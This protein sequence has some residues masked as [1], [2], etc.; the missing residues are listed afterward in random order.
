MAADFF[1][2]H[3]GYLELFNQSGA[4]AASLRV[5]RQEIAFGNERLVG[6]ANWTNV[7]RSFDGAR[8]SLGPRV[9]A[10][11]TAPA[12]WSATLAAATVEERGTHFGA[13]P[14]GATRD[15]FMM[16]LYASRALPWDA[17][18]DGTALYD[19][20]GHYR[21]YDDA[22]R[23]TLDSRFKT[24]LGPAPLRLDVEGA[25]QQ[26]RQVVVASGQ[27]QSIEAWLASARLT[28]IPAGRRHIVAGLGT[29]L[30][31]GDDSPVDGHYS[32]FGTMYATNHPFYG[33]MDVIG[34]PATTTKDRGLADALATASA[35]LT[36]NTSMRAEVH[37]FTMMTGSDRSLGWE[38]DLGLPLRISHAATI[39]LGFSV[40][41]ASTGA[42]AVG[43]GERGQTKNW[44]YAQF[45]VAF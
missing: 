34:D 35:E 32:A 30:L 11:A 1:E 20:G 27:S 44:A 26:G 13:Q 9:A 40:F 16:T 28:T 36:T 22:T 18:L 43:L 14:T 42:A 7:A 5:G 8:L 19:R 38:T 12:N 29:D 21:A 24:R 39:E 15:H 3:Q 33:L 41:R 4:L 25:W 45:S 31:S 17:V 2:L 10:G 23:A 37:R 6:A